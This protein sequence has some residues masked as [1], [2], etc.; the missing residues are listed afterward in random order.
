MP[1]HINAIAL[2]VCLLKPGL[3]LTSTLLR[4]TEA[5]PGFFNRGGVQH[6]K[7]KSSLGLGCIG[8]CLI[9]SKL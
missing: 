7:S 5:D 9:S 8:M 3:C 2:A 6:I 4:P 1:S